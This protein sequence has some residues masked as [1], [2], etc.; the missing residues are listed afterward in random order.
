[1]KSV[2]INRI[3]LISEI[4]RNREKHIKDYEEAIKDYKILVLKISQENL[5]LAKSGVLKK[6]DE[7]V[8]IPSAPRVYTKE[9]DRAQMMLSLSVDEVIE[10]EAGEFNQLVLDEWHWKASF[11]NLNATYKSLL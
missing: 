8:D 1:M 3:E 10:L 7:I 4:E 9:Y 6:F 11:S 2:R 5:E